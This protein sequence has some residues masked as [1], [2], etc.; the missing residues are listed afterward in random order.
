[1]AS[2]LSHATPSD[3]SSSTISPEQPDDALG[4]ADHGVQNASGEFSALEMADD[5]VS[6]EDSEMV[7]SNMT[8]QFPEMGSG[9]ERDEGPVPDADVERKSIASMDMTTDGILVQDNSQSLF[10]PEDSK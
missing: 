4:P 10:L 5:S 9:A 8:P 3:R 6:P 1:M 2:I 7:F